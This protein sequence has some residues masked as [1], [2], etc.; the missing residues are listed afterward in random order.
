MVS[1]IIPAYN[2]SEF[3]AETIESVISQ[4]FLDWECVIMDDG[5]IDGTY[6]KAQEYCLQDSR[7]QC[8]KQGNGGPSIARN[9]A[10]KR[11]FG[12]Y[13]LP[14]DADDKIA[15]TYI[16]KAVRWFE[17][18]PDTTLV[19]GKVAI[20]GNPNSIIETPPFNY[21][22]F[23]WA[24][25]IISSAMFRRSDFL[26]TGGYNPNM[27]EGLEDW[28]FWLSLLDKDSIVHCLDDV[29]YYIRVR[30]DSRTSNARKY[31]SSLHQQ[32]IKNHPDIYS[33]YMTDIISPYEQIITLKEEITHLRLQIKGIQSS[34][35]YKV[36][37]RI[38]KLFSLFRPKKW[39]QRN[40]TITH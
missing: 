4:T 40:Q 26:L 19:Y 39:N 12:K 20:L 35:A 23:I 8:F 9:N 15:N 28:D 24:N 16:E 3:I 33:K 17:N 32:I 18:H 37:K 1:V 27:K 5:S 30:E 2:C 25:T 38:I 13:I 6:E 22:T 10:I 36:G 31:H 21:D 34:Y 29:V 7:I 14:V 11:S